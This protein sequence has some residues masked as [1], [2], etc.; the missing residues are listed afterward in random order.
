MRPALLFFLMIPFLNCTTPPAARPDSGPQ[1][2]WLGRAEIHPDGLPASFAWP[3]SG[4]SVRFKGTEL[5]I[6]WE[7]ANSRIPGEEKPPEVWVEIQVDSLAPV[8][9]MLSEGRKVDILAQ[10][11]PDSEHTLTVRRRTETFTGIL[12]LH[13]ADL[14][15][16]GEWLPAPAPKPWLLFIGNSITCGYGVEGDKA[17]CSFTPGTENAL[18]SF[19]A[20]TAAEL[21]H[22]WQAIAYSGKGMYQNYDRTQTGTMPE[23][24][25]KSWGSTD[26][27][28]WN[29]KDPLAPAA[30]F[31][32][33][34]TND[35]AHGVPDR[36]AF[37][38]ATRGLLSSIRQ[39]YPTQPV[40]LLTGSM[41]TG[42]PLRTLR[43]YLNEV[44]QTAAAEGDPAIYRYD[45]TAQGPL[46]MGCDY[47][48]NV[49]Q[50][51]LNGKELG[52]WVK[53]SSLIG[54]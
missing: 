49:A 14:S 45:L 22:D 48:P 43:S 16:G 41:M 3:A 5:R 54:K 51:Q 42:K 15:K 18:V 28:A 26:A 47:H 6:D 27:P 23:L 33:L 40:V 17:T 32:N 39:H 30:I 19:A 29:F 38:A 35:F 36:K 34:G 12:T 37:I 2:R 13:A 46:G 8:K 7:V 11:L 52:L 10:N 1:F 53:N 25:L 50:Q 20:L 9:M 44:R 24:W 21:G 4:F 31:I